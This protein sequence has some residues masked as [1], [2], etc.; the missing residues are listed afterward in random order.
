MRLLKRGYTTLEAVDAAVNL[1]DL[2][3]CDVHY[4]EPT[5]RYDSWRWR[6]GGL[7]SSPPPRPMV[8]QTWIR[9]FD[10]RDDATEPSSWRC[11]LW[12]CLPWG[13]YGTAGIGQFFHQ[14]AA[15]C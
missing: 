14:L 7:A 6:N 11:M 13:S 12:F 10:T 2:A 9:V 3:Q 5:P 4:A 8:V 15:S 1:L